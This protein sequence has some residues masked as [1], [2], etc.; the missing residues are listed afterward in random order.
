[1]KR[2]RICAVIVNNEIEA[3]KR[4][5]PLVNLFE[6]RI[7]LIG[8][9][10]T[11]LAKQL[12]KP[13]IACNRCAEEGGSWAGSEA[14]RREELLRAVEL[15]ADMVDIELITG[16]L[17]EM[18][19]MIKRK[20]KCLIS[21]HD[22]KETPPLERLRE[23]VKK[24]I[25]A[26]ADIGKVVTTAQKFQDNLTVLQLIADFPQSRIVSFAMGGLG[27][28]SR[29]L[30][31]L[32]GGEFSYAAIKEGSESAAGQITAADLSKIYRMLKNE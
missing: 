3:V 16:N 4:A 8:A 12:K 5:E 14:R 31:P 6:V 20:A 29:I 19:A 22:F 32:L 9:G 10:W 18:V 25:A 1:M 17:K 30:C 2:P 21:C 11:E 13:W 26:G 23:I 24:E 7:D 28:V 15:G 27:T